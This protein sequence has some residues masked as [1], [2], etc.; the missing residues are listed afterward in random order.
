LFA[1]ASA[2]VLLS[3]PHPSIMSGFP[4]FEFGAGVTPTQAPATVASGAGSA[5]KVDVPAP[6]TPQPVSIMDVAKIARVDGQLVMNVLAT[7]KADVSTPPE[8]V[9]YIRDEDFKEAVDTTKPEGQP[10][11]PLQKGQM[12]YFMKVLREHVS[13][14]PVAGASGGQPVPPS[15]AA[16]AVVEKRKISE[17]LDQ[18]DD[19]SYIPLEPA[20]VAKMRDFHRA[21]TGGDPP[22]HERPSA[23]QLSALAHRL[24]SGKAPYVD[25]AVFGPYGRRQAKLLQFTAQVFVHGELVTRQLKGPGTYQGWRASWAV[26]RS[27]MVMLNAASPSALDRYAR[28]IEELVTL[29]PQAWGVV[30]VADETMRSERWDILMEN[31]ATDYTW[32]DA[33]RDS[34]FGFDTSSAHWW[35]MHVLGPLGGGARHNPTMTVAAVEGLV[36]GGFTPRLEHHPGEQPSGRKNNQKS[37]KGS[38]PNKPKSGGPTCHD[39]NSARGCVRPSFAWRH[40]CSG[41][42]SSFPLHRC[43][44][45]NPGAK[46]RKGSEKGQSSGEGTASGKKRKGAKSSGAPSSK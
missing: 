31:K 44:T 15:S 33:I 30:S 42:G 1:W 25:F 16:P 35:F 14:S 7:L 4:K 17:V 18:I 41:C 13:S 8:H 9:A 26:F 45:C 12:A 11:S 43:W 5:A 32:E 34:A 24:K 19:T 22:D 37:S 38:A 39:F 28:G 2:L 27:A 10:L 46:P 3:S 6:S 29:Y 20:A 21:V 36:P 40:A 23:E